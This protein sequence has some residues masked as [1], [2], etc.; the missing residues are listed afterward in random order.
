MYGDARR[1]AL[2]RAALGLQLFGALHVAENQDLLANT[3]FVDLNFFRTQVR[4]RMMAFVAR[5]EIEKHF[6]RGG[7]DDRPL[8]CVWRL[9]CQHRAY[10]QSKQNR[11]RA[12]AGK[13]AS[14]HV[15]D[16]FEPQCLRA[17]SVRVSGLCP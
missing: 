6:S 17:H 14:P 7:M 3:I 9:S 4:D 12:N 8:I 11:K 15:I 10:R 2:R 5:Y 13:H 1:S 16:D